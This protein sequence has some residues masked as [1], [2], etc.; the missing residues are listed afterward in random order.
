MEQRIIVQEIVNE[1]QEITSVETNQ[2]KTVIRETPEGERETV[3]V[4]DIAR[5]ERKEIDTQINRQ[6]STTIGRPDFMF[7]ARVGLDSSFSA[8]LERR[9]VGGLYGGVYATNQGEV[10]LSLSITF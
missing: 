8:S 5:T 3:I 2:R 1:K 9:L 6:E 7:G 10:G 4:E